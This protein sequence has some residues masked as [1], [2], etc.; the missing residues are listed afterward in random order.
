[1]GSVVEIHAADETLIGSQP[2]LVDDGMKRQPAYPPQGEQRPPIAP[3]GARRLW[4]TSRL[5]AALVLIPTLPMLFFSIAALVFYYAAPARFGNLIARLPGDQF[6]RSALAFAP[7]ALLAV[8]I[9]AALYALERPQVQA[10]ADQAPD[11]LEVPA[12][13]SG[14]RLLAAS[15]L[16]PSLPTLLLLVAAQV[17]SFV[18]PGRFG[19]LIEPLPGDRYLRMAL[20]FGVL[21]LVGVVV[22]AAFFALRGAAAGKRGRPGFAL[23]PPNVAIGVTLTAS[24]PLLAVSL[25]AFALYHLS[26]GR[27]ERLMARLSTETFV[28]MALILAPVTLFAIVLLAALYLLTQPGARRPASPAE[29]EGGARDVPLAT[30]GV[31]GGLASTAIIGLGVLAAAVWLV[32]RGSP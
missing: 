27:F 7:A 32:L 15:V 20:P 24:L 30:W 21:A 10:E 6:I 13:R 29:R 5:L 3:R 8:V 4:S 17:L 28:R 9:L 14:I 19:D 12:G 2:V 1:M 22:T 25:A 31:A 18:A 26:R 16:I 23:S 11:V